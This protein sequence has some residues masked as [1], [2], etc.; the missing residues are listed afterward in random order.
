MS[1]GLQGLTESLAQINQKIADFEKT[2][3][4][5]DTAF[6][7][8]ENLAAEAKLVVNVNTPLLN[9]FPTKQG[10]GKAAAWKEITSFGSDPSS[11]FFAEGGTPSGRTTVYADRSETYRLLGLDGGVTGFAVAAGA[12]FQDQLQLEKRNTIFHLKN[13]EEDALINAP[14][15]GQSYSGLLTQITT[16]NGSY[17]ASS[18]GTPGSA[19]IADLDAL[20]QSSWDKGVEISIFVVRSTEAKLI[21]Q[22]LTSDSGNSA[23][24]VIMPGPSGITGGFFVNKYLSPITGRVAEIVPDIKHT[25]ATIIG[26]VERLPEP[27]VGQGDA[28]I[29]IDTLLDYALSDV[30]VTADIFSF[31]VKKYATL[32]IPARKFCGV[33]TDF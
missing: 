22:A 26:V 25:T 15:T 4:T 18:T 20:L 27:V 29:L 13:L 16:A 30:P 24:R 2:I 31:R 14:G 8:R 5:G 7:I 17:S 3:A 9:R 23:L 21:S 1:N 10:S 33:I 6:P 11:V 32:A 19:L 12:S 28:G